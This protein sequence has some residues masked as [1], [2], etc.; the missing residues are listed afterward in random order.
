MYG[1]DDAVHLKT[2]PTFDDSDPV[3]G[4]RVVQEFNMYRAARLSEFV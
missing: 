1:A 3:K 2:T 4:G